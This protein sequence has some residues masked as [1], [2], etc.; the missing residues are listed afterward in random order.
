MP[1]ASKDIVPLSPVRAHLTEL[2]EEAAKGWADV[3]AGR[4]ISVAEL[5]AKYGRK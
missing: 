4:Y 1:I 3:I 5:K 2:I